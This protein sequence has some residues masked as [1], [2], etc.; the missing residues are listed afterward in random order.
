MEY[1]VGARYRVLQDFHENGFDF[2][3]ERVM[4]V[5]CVLQHATQDILIE[6]DGEVFFHRDTNSDSEDVGYCFSRVD[7]DE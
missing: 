5:S 1:R 7:E 3:A 4:M 2:K 6:F